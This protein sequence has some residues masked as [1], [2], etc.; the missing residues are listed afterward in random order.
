[1]KVRIPPYPNFK[2]TEEAY[3]RDV[4]SNSQP[5][6]TTEGWTNQLI[7]IP[8]FESGEKRV[9][10][11][12]P[13]KHRENVY[14]TAFPNPIHLFLSLAI[15]HFE[16]S[17]KVKDENFPKCGKRFGENIYL[18]D[19]EENGT[20]DC[21]NHHIKY[22]VSSIIMAV[23][24]IEAFLNHVIPN[25][26]VYKTY[27]NGKLIELEKN[28]IE[29]TKISF[30]EKL[31]EVIPQMLGQNDFWFSYQTDKSNILELYKHRKDIIHLKTNAK[32][33][34][35]RYFNVIDKMLDFDIQSSI[36]S[37]IKFMNLVE[38]NFIELE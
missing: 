17:E 19:I 9:I 2:I 38:D 33:D 10:Q 23:T 16:H 22:R 12:R 32:D 18:L 35:D 24:S 30:R 36:E 11:T 27:R 21:Y 13:I 6:R 31:T 37:T 15:E 5:E 4:V 29:S 34:F 8:E 14:I 3:N 20:H 28:Q 7:I 25:D 26:F 1:M